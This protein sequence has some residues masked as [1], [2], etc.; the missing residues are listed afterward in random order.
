MSFVVD[1]FEQFAEKAYSLGSEN[2]LLKEYLNNMSSTWKAM[3]R[4][5]KSEALQ[6][7]NQHN[8]RAGEDPNIPTL[9]IVERDTD[10]DGTKELMVEY[11]RAGKGYAGSAKPERKTSDY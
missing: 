5:E 4:E 8:A 7:L 10:G 6:F 11:E 1:E 2:P 9:A 3:N